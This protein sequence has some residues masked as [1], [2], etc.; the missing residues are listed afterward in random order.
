[1]IDLPSF[2]G[3]IIPRPGNYPGGQKHFVPD[4]S[5]ISFWIN[6]YKDL[7]RSGEF[8]PPVK[9]GL[10]N[11][12]PYFGYFGYRFHPVSYIPEYYHL[13]IDI[14]GRAKKG[15][16]PISHGILEY[17]GFGHINGNYVMISHPHVTTLDGYVMHSLY[18]HLRTCHVKFNS[19]QKMLREISL[20]NYPQIEIPTTEVIG[21]IGN[22]GN[23]KYSPS[24]LHLQIEFRN[25]EGHVVV[26]DPAQAL[27]LPHNKNKSSHLRSE[28]QFKLFR[29]KHAEDLKGWERFWKIKD[30]EKE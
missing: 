30:N 24:H 22:T 19:R 4:D 13:G 10:K 21:E 6:W 28:Q 17:S 5:Q 27:G 11:V 2:S 18:L 7:S 23:G 14:S 20:H 16:L 29:K 25:K 1:M 3:K 15:V 8:Q 12:D 9:S 26:I